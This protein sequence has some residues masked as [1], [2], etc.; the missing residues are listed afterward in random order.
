[1]L[2]FL[3]LLNQLGLLSL[4]QRLVFQSLR[5]VSMYLILLPQCC[6]IEFVTPQTI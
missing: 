6:H 3:D 1:V 2:L 4:G 5:W